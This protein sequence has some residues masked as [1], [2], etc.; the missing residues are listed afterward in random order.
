MNRNIRGQSAMEFL[1]TYGWA[2]LVVLIAIGALAY[3][4]VLNPA[5]FLP[6]SC[7][8][9]PGVSCNNFK[10]STTTA[11]F[12]VQNGLGVQVSCFNLTISTPNQ[13]TCTS[14]LSLVATS[15]SGLCLVQPI[16]SDGE[17]EKITITCAAG[18]FGNVG[19]RFKA[20][21]NVSFSEGSGASII[22][23]RRRGSI[24]TQI[25]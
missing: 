1:M 9:F 16:L 7:V 3:F 15:G 13:G 5:R 20:D 6:T 14:A 8:I 10:I 12:V 11:E 21:L 19:D 4:G 23:H 25:E 2:I 24:A 18:N 17:E 22:Y